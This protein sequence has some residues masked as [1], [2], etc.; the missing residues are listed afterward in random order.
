ME[1][2]T[3]HELQSD[4]RLVVLPHPVIIGHKPW[5]GLKEEGYV[6]MPVPVHKK[7]DTTTAVTTV[8]S[9]GNQANF[10]VRTLIVCLIPLHLFIVSYLYKLL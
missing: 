10:C 5:T 2:K 4:T 1:N 3:E 9:S 8:R 7:S 6:V